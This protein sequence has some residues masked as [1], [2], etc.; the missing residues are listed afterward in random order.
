VQ[1]EACTAQEAQAM[2]GHPTDREFL[3]TVHSGM[4]SN[5]PVTPTAMQNANQIFVPNLAG[6]RGQTVRRPPE[7]ETTN[8]VKIPRAIQEQHQRVTVA[9]DVMFTN[10]VPFLVRISQGI[11]LIT[12]EHTP[13]RTVKQLAAG[14]RHIMDFFF[15]EDSKWVLW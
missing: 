9:V 14:I 11:N 3:G 7:S 12:A 4:I 1:E 13:S 15:A 10:G 6:V 5:Y 2:L 8:H